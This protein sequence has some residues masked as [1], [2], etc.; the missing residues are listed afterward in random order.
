MT[1]FVDKPEHVLLATTVPA[2]KVTVP[3]THSQA[4]LRD[5]VE[6]IARRVTLIRLTDESAEFLARNG[7]WVELDR[8]PTGY[9][10]RVTREGRMREVVGERCRGGDRSLS[11]NGIRL[12]QE[13]EGNAPSFIGAPRRVS[14]AIRVSSVESS[15][16]SGS[17]WRPRAPDYVGPSE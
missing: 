8:M 13:V 9:R 2:L 12:Y 6:H 1:H 7:A 14:S 4:D 17:A 3:A 11:D 15:D 16:Q 5:A 10:V